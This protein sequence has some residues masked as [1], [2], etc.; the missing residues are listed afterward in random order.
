LKEVTMSK[1][2]EK[3]ERISEGS[4][5]PIGFG[6]AVNRT[7]IAPMLII[8]SVPAA[9]TQLTGVVGKEGIDAILIT[10]ENLAKDKKVLAKIDNAKIGVPWGVSMDAVTGE[11]IEQL[12]GMGCDYVIF[13]PARTPA[14]VL[15][16]DK[17]GKVLKIDPTLTD[18]MIRAISRL[19]VDAVF[20]SPVSEEEPHF[21]IQ[22]LMAYERLA[23]G[24]GKHLLAAFP[25][26]KPSADI[27]SLWG[28][29]V[30]GVAV[31]LTAEQP[32]QRL[33][34]IKEAILKLPATRK[35]SKEKIR[36]TLPVEKV[37]SEAAESEED[38]EEQA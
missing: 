7:K 23:G 21:T 27:E 5:Q 4:G 3:L 29:G 14:A 2:L 34:Q 37:S 1:L 15:N 35:K 8:A 24:T 17:I 30:R 13:G 26:G 36:A 28:L 31:D 25:P 6:A 22:Q 38:D 16:E 18:G 12:I 19:S 11:E 33:A 32:E 9:N 20:L 10:V